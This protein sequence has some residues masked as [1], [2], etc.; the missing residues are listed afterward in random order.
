MPD[1]LL[2]LQEAADLLGVHPRTL[3]R[4]IIAGR[5]P[6]D[7]GT[8]ETGST[9]KIGYFSQEGE[10][11]DEAMAGNPLIHEGYADPN[12][13]YFDGAE[14]QDKSEN[15]CCCA[16]L[17]DLTKGQTITVTDLPPGA[18]VFAFGGWLSIPPQPDETSAVVGFGMPGVYTIQIWAP[19]HKTKTLQV[20]VKGYAE[21]PDVCGAR[22]GL[23][24]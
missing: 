10:E 11:L 24:S 23:V 15:P 2:S 9:V 16:G 7:G 14:I 1:K 5:L 12:L 18:E 4:W 17:I 21:C 22:V 13:H 8:V 6:A 19:R 3:R 20:E